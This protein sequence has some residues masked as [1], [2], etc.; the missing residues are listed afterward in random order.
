[1]REEVVLHHLID[2]DVIVLRRPHVIPDH[3]DR[4]ASREGILSAIGVLILVAED[5]LESH[6]R[7]HRRED[8]HRHQ[9]RS[10]RG[11]EDDAVRCIH[12]IILDRLGVTLGAPPLHP[13]VHPVRDGEGLH[14]REEL[15]PL[16]FH[17][18]L[19][20]QLLGHGVDRLE[21]DGLALG[22][23]DVVADLGDLLFGAVD[24][25]DVGNSV[26]HD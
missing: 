22:A 21:G 18:T 25:E 23:L 13:P 16:D 24:R 4:L 3:V 11:V 2:G 6:L 1:M 17:L 15:N 10:G 26:T 12:H 7:E 14:A 20:L 19:P 9:R 5:D 8:G